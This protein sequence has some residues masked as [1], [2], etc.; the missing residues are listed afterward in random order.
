MCGGGRLTARK[1]VSHLIP[2]SANMPMS[3]STTSRRLSA[4]SLAGFHATCVCMVCACAF[5]CAR[6]PPSEHV[7]GLSLWTRAHELAH[8]FTYTPAA[9]TQERGTSG[10]HG[11]AHRRKHKQHT[12]T[13]THTSRTYLCGIQRTREKRTLF[14]KQLLA[15]SMSIFLEK[16]RWRTDT[17][18]ERGDGE[19][20][21]GGRRA[22]ARGEG[23][24]RYER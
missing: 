6:A 15:Q 22:G 19:C 17:K 24:K 8:S 2:S 5:V 14:A 13:H 18:G 21:G 16:G 10:W 20:E 7:G 4:N 11:V 12:H 1:R 9:Y 3:Q 23:E